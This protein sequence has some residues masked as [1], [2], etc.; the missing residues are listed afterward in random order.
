MTDRSRDLR[1]HI[2]WALP[3]VLV[4]AL[5]L[6][7]GA[8][9]LPVAS[10]ATTVDAPMAQT[11][12]DFTWEIVYPNS[13]QTNPP[14]IHFHT[15]VFPTASTG[16]ALGGPNWW[17][18]VLGNGPSFIVK[19]TNG[20][21]NWTAVQIPNT[22]RA[23]RG[24]ACKDENNCWIA[25]GPSANSPMAQYTTDGGATWNGIVNNANW[26]G[27]L[28]SAGYTGI[29]TTVLLG[30]TGYDPLTPGRGASF[31]RSTNGVT[32]NGVTASGE[33]QQWDFSC[34]APG[35][36]FSAAKNS[37]YATT[38][39][40]LSWSRRT[41]PSA[42]YYGV[43]CTNDRTCWEAGDSGKI[44]FTTDA[45]ATWGSALVQNLPAGRP[46]FWDV[47]MY[48]NARGFAV[49][50]T[51]ADAVT[52]E[53]INGQGMIYRTDNGTTWN[54]IPAPAP[55]GQAPADI[56]DVHIVSMN[57]IFVLDWAGRIWRG[58]TGPPPTATPTNTPTATI[59][60][61]PTSTSTPTRT[62]TATPT[63]TA[64]AT[65][66]STPT[67]TPTPSTATILGMAFADINGNNYPDAGEPG[68]ADAV[69]GLQVGASTVI[70][71]TS[72][73]NGAF[74]FDGVAP[75]IYSVRGLQ[76]PAGHSLSTSVSTIGVAANTSW[77]L[78]TPFV[79]GIPT[80][81]LYC[82][83]L[84]QVQTSFP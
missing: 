72:G 84:P 13:T 12:N 16:Y 3:L 54:Q 49:G 28:W 63:H 51:N 58:R 52:D 36:C 78:Y 4:V 34:P 6:P 31:L 26:S 42:L 77:M 37:L 66:T 24:L 45:G 74:A 81:P 44:V 29:P 57:E 53:C 21:S 67:A 73:V 1:R 20:G 8:G 60:P 62:P 10:G 14:E 15:I 30:T 83:Y 17:D 27:F 9:L 59:T 65:P 56:M 40:G 79:V 64:T 35:I 76:A 46:R 33:Y 38:N 43:S 47:E 32:F 61:T 41:P 39:D 18:G 75:G 50:C 70:S 69:I 11:G 80:P 48:D 55:A 7:V 19:T 23:M 71:A 25:G 82:T 2:R 5:T 22:R 68:L